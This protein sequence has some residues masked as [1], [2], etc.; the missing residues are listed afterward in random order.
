MV[1]VKCLIAISV[2]KGGRYV[3]EYDWYQGKF[4]KQNTG[5]TKY[6]VD[7]GITFKTL[8]IKDLEVRWVEHNNCLFVE[9]K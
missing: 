1:L 5:G 7:F 9:E 8:G 4:I 2:I 6:Q 3:P